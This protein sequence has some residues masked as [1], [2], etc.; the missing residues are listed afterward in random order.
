MVEQL[1]HVFP[2]AL[3]TLVELHRSG[4][5]TSGS[6]VAYQKPNRNRETGTASVNR[7]VNTNSLILHVV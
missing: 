4:E 2:Q 1:L 7:T 6:L 3:V 5:Q